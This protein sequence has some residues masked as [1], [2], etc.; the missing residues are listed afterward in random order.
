[1]TWV[2]RQIKGK[3]LD[4]GIAAVTLVLVTD[5]MGYQGTKAFAPSEHK[6]ITEYLLK[7]DRYMTVARKHWEKFADGM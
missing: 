4:D 5:S 2:Q 1:M 7:Q 6:E 3:S